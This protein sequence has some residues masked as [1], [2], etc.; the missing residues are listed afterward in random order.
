MQ[1]RNNRLVRVLTALQTELW[2]LPPSMHTRLCAIAEAHAAGGGIEAAQHL[3]AAGMKSE[4]A[5][6]YSTDGDV[7]II[8]VEGV[9]GRKFSSALNSS[10]V[11]SVDVLQRLIESAVADP[12]VSA[13]VLSIDSPGGLARGVPEAAH[14]V[15][16]ANMT[17]PVV[18][19]VDGQASSA[20][21]WIASQA[22]AIYATESASVG[23]IGVYSA[24]LD[25]SL[26]MAAAGARVEVFKSGIH[27][28]AGLPGT[29]LTDDQRAMIQAGV[30]SLG[31]AFRADVR[32]GRGRDISDDDMQGQSFDV[33]A[34]LAAGLIDS[35]STLGKAVADA[36][37]LAQLRRG[38]R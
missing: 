36:S 13:L 27:K 25:T 26:A 30:D 6:E 34:G 4:P 28:G 33:A 21:Y 18:A 24:L 1:D 23:S 9:I 37:R 11:T 16:A 31:V 19:F 22:S 32:A 2:L 38:S 10:G 7:A 12:R 17:K 8:P 14:A 3:A 15:A 20:A 35:V 29:S 5:R